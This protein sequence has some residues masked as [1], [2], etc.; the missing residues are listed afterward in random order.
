MFIIVE[1]L[2]IFMII[3]IVKFPKYILKNYKNRQY[4]NV[5]EKNNKIAYIIGGVIVTIFLVYEIL[6]LS[7]YI[8]GL[9]T[10]Y[11]R[12]LGSSIPNE[13]ISETQERI[14]HILPIFLGFIILAIV[15]TLIVLIIKNY[16]K[17]VD[18]KEQIENNLK[19]IKIYMY[20]ILAIIIIN[21]LFFP[22]TFAIY[23]F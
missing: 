14:Y 2:F 18:N 15:V 8:V 16:R 9:I 3:W 19:K 23:S 11:N 12:L 10:G 17:K 13:G 5:E 6:P 1:L 4:G 21:I 22:I 7:M 20:I